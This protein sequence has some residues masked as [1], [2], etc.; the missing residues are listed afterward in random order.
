MSETIN[1]KYLESEKQLVA[2]DYATQGDF[3]SKVVKLVGEKKYQD[4]LNKVGKIQFYAKKG[5]IEV[6]IS[7][8]KTDYVIKNKSV[9]DKL[10]SFFKTK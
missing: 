3:I 6:S 2:E 5:D 4:I 8:N 10:K 1:Q 9:L 7:V